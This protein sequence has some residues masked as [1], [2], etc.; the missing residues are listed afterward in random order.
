MVNV[1]EYKSGTTADDAA[2]GCIRAA[3]SKASTVIDRL[4]DAQ[5]FLS[6]TAPQNLS[7]LHR[8]IALNERQIVGFVDFNPLDGYVKML[9][10]DPE[11]QGQ[12]V[13]SELLQMANGASEVPL[14]LRTQAVNDGALAFYLGQGFE[15]VRG[16]LEADWHGARVVWIT[17]SKGAS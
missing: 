11:W 5:A 17:L 7:S 4:P 13:A 12:G 16:E 3:A 8:I 14:N 1:F 10:V 15:V 2:C 6:D 9:F